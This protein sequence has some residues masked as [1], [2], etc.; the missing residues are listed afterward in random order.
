[1]GAAHRDRERDLGA[2]AEDAVGRV[3]G[4]QDLADLHHAGPQQGEHLVYPVREVARRGEAVGGRGLVLGRQAAGEQRPQPIGHAGPEP[5]VRALGGQA[6]R[7]RLLEVTHRD[8]VEPALYQRQHHLALGLSAGAGVRPG[9]AGLEQQ[10]RVDELAQRPGVPDGGGL[11]GG[12]V[13]RLGRHPGRVAGVLE[14]AAV[15]RGE[16]A[17]GEIGEEG[18]PALSE[19]DVGR[20]QVAVDG[21]GLGQRQ[22]DAVDEAEQIG[23]RDAQLE[24]ALQGGV[25]RH[26]E[27][28]PPRRERHGGLEPGQEVVTALLQQRD[29][30]QRAALAGLEQILGQR[31][32]RGEVM[33]G[34][35]LLEDHLAALHVADHARAP[36]AAPPEHRAEHPLPTEAVG[37]VIAVH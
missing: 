19:D 29:L 7:D 26:H 14:Q 13:A 33:P 17:G 36:P 32:I 35:R 21:L 15:V 12:A 16:R 9:L 10:P 22:R 24:L 28:H 27:A 6:R 1:M 5:G 8:L 18:L 34:Q 4:E 31:R 20:P 2:V 11:G 23:E 3:G 25:L 30:L 37:E